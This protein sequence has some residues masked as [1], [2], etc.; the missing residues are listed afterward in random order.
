MADKQQLE[1]F[2]A[3]ADHILNNNVDYY[4]IPSVKLRELASTY[5]KNRMIILS[6]DDKHEKFDVNCWNT[7]IDK[8]VLERVL[9]ISK[10]KKL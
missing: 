9:K 1:N 4:E 2:Y 6:W 8:K 7:E 5:N 10:L 3:L